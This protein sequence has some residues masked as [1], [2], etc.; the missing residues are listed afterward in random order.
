[1]SSG[2][3]NRPG[4]A[5]WSTDNRKYGSTTTVSLAATTFS[6]SAIDTAIVRDGRWVLRI[7]QDWMAQ[8][9]SKRTAT[10]DRQPIDQT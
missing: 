6:S 2:D 1:L 5:A 10:W 3:A 7:Q 9:R 4:E 8:W